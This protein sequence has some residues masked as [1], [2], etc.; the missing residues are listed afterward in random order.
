MVWIHKHSLELAELAKL[1]GFKNGFFLDVCSGMFK[2]NELF[3]YP[4]LVSIQDH[5]ELRLF[6][7]EVNK[8][9]NILLLIK[10]VMWI[11][12]WPN[13]GSRALYPER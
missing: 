10:A 9:N 11:R 5:A 12:F 3:R 8:N 7:L 6:N 2:L 13:S 4:L 1:I